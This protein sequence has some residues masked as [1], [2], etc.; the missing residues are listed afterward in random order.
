M[1]GCRIRLHVDAMPCSHNLTELSIPDMGVFAECMEH[2]RAML[3]V[4]DVA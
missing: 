1:G 4:S 3:R 2:A